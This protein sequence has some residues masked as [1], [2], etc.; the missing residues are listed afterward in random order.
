MNGTQVEIIEKRRARAGIFPTS[1]LRCARCFRP[2]CNRFPPIAPEKHGGD[3]RVGRKREPGANPARASDCRSR[4]KS[5]GPASTA[6]PG[7]RS[8]AGRMA[9]IL[10]V[11]IV[12]AAVGGTLYVYR[13]VL[14]W[15]GPAIVA[16]GPTAGS[17]DGQNHDEAP[18]GRGESGHKPPPLPDLPATQASPAS[19]A[20][21]RMLLAR[22]RPMRRPTR[23]PRRPQRMCQP[24]MRSSSPLRHWRR[25]RRAP[26][27]VIPAR[28]PPRRPRGL[29]P[30]TP[31][32]RATNLRALRWP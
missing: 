8:S 7:G 30:P 19:E 24:P 29:H 28:R 10:G 26:A 1:I 2:C 18:P 23:L 31:R 5:A 17:S 27:L 6:T 25:V 21:A 15:N 32:K 4:A 16:Q 12:L 3:R 20:R 22:R 13:D 14:P 11:L 9:A